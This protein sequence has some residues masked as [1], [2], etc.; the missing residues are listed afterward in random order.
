MRESGERGRDGERRS[1]KAMI[2]HVINDFYARHDQF[3]NVLI[4]PSNFFSTFRLQMKQNTC[5]DAH[6]VE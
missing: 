6:N 4:P 2:M 5:P 1:E 3:F